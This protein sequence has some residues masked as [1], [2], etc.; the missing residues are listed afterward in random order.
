MI[1]IIKHHKIR[2]CCFGVTFLFIGIL[3]ILKYKFKI[4]LFHII[5]PEQLEQQDI[6]FLNVSINNWLTII[7]ILGSIFGIPW[8]LHRYDC[9]RREKQQEKAGGI[10]KKFADEFM[11][12]LE[13]INI[14]LTN[15]TKFQKLLKSINPAK[16]SN[17]STYELIE[18]SNN[19][20][21]INDFLNLILSKEIQTAYENFLNK[22]YNEKEKELFNS[23]F[24]SL[25]ES[26]LNQ[27]ESIC[28]DIS[29]QAAG[30]QYIYQSLH[31]EFLK[32][33]HI[34]SILISKNNTNNFDKYYTNI[35]YVYNIWNKQKQKD[36]KLFE[37]T[38]KKI[39]KRESKCKKDV[40]KLLTKKPDKI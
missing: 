9:T 7:Y 11:D 40:H 17:F 3:L 5:T 31:Q 30:S 13:T 32:S 24:I 35:I 2:A 16:L 38:M 37:K 28:I 36:K 34:L 4:E 33:V 19:P 6:F 12:K 25:V 21:I 20:N 23:K 15:N 18:I 10:A 29:S 26:T 27:L 1:E 22:N 14:I 8:A 39:E